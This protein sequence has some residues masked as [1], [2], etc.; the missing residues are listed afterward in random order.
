MDLVPAPCTLTVLLVDDSETQR[1]L[2][3][4]ILEVG[5]CRVIAAENGAQALTLL[6]ERSFDAVVADGEMPLIDGYQLCRLIKSDPTLGSMPLLLLTGKRHGFRRLRA[7]TCGADRFEP[8]RPPPEMIGL[9]KTVAQLV[10]DH[11][12]APPGP[13]P[14]PPPPQDLHGWLSRLGAMVEDALL[15][16]ALRREVA[17]LY[18]GSHDV[19]AMAMAFT[20]LLEELVFPG[21]IAIVYPGLAGRELLA[22]YAGDVEPALLEQVRQRLAEAGALDPSQEIQWDRGPDDDGPGTGPHAAR[23]LLRA[24]GMGTGPGTGRHDGWV[25]LATS[26]QVLDGHA[27]LIDAAFEE[28][29]RVLHVERTHMD[30]YEAAVHDELTGAWNRRYLTDA[31]GKELAKYNRYGGELSVL[32]VDI[33][34]FKSVNDSYGHGTGDDVLKAVTRQIE[35]CIRSADMLARLGGEEFL[36]VCPCSDPDAARVVAERLRVAIAEAIV[37]QLPPGRRITVSIG[38]AAAHEGDD[39]P[40]LIA[41]ADAELYRAKGSGRN[42]VCQAA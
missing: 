1:A 26:G 36:V 31:L 34:H 21:A 8:K 38:V 27:A 5:G 15:V 40:T 11:P 29:G 9:A 4:T 30:L 41:R 6:A 32:M 3:Q 42:R 7:Q 28:L 25:A 20:V 24:V 12:R 33:D 23:V 13:Q 22:R 14:T 2:L 17:G 35:K 16:A 39:A 10:Q 19:G 18:D 37:P